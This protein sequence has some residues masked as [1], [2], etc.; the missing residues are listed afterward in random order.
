MGF[1]TGITVS[2]VIFVAVGATI[3]L[4]TTLCGVCGK[5]KRR[6]TSN[7]NGINDDVDLERGIVPHI[8]PQ[9][10][11]GPVDMTEVSN[12][13]EVSVGSDLRRTNTHPPLSITLGTRVQWNQLEYEISQRMATSLER[14]SS[15]EPD[16]SYSA[17]LEKFDSICPKV[18][19]H[20]FLESMEWEDVDLGRL[21]EVSPGGGF[22]HRQRRPSLRGQQYQQDPQS[23][24]R[25][26]T[27][28]EQ[29][30]DE[31]CTICIG[32]FQDP[33]G[34]PADEVFIRMLPCRHIFHDQCILECLKSN[35]KKCPNCNA[36]IPDL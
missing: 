4:F 24:H 22:V 5:D 28:P 30:I 18:S 1:Q 11:R 21:Y 6:N 31:T 2:V 16:E 27:I 12:N 17:L 13:N 36:V 20:E 3:F 33:D 7:S 10:S 29:E 25:G 35:R 9:N 15:N 23:Q 14:A 32:K 19:L 26:S 8:D 34:P